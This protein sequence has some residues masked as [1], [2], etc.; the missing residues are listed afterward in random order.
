PNVS[1]PYIIESSHVTSSTW[2]TQDSPFTW[3]TY[4][5]IL[6]WIASLVWITL[7]LLKQERKRNAVT[8]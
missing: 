7:D 2:N 4:L 6:F 8:S 1:H 3:R 5:W